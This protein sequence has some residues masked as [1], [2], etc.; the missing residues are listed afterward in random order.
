MTKKPTNKQAKI[1]QKMR[2]PK[3]SDIATDSSAGGDYYPVSCRCNFLK[4]W[5]ITNKTSIVHLSFSS[6]IHRQ[7]LKEIRRLRPEA[8][9][10]NSSASIIYAQAMVLRIFGTE[11]ERPTPDFH[12]NP[13]LRNGTQFQQ[14]IWR[15]ISAIK[16]GETI[17]YGELATT[18]G[19]PGGARAAGR[20]C[21]KNP[22]ALLIPCHRV[23]AANGPGG[24]AGD[25]AMKMQLLATEK[26]SEDAQSVQLSD[27]KCSATN[28]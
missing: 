26:R 23:I 28:F 16:P 24:F 7:A 27:I 22:L 25:P 21:N 15:I 6:S 11:Q 2:A 12:H 20:A 4:F 18:A 8:K 19:S 5:M 1:R 10:S 14:R 9:L 17:T 13:F 3:P